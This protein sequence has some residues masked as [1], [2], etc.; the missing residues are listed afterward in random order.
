MYV[1]ATDSLIS[2][3]IPGDEAMHGYTPVYP[4]MHMDS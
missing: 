4:N 3:S 2:R 1:L